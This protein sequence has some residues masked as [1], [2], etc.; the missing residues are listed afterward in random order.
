MKKSLC[1]LAGRYDEALQLARTN[2]LKRNDWTFIPANDYSKLRGLRNFILIL[3]GTFDRVCDRKRLKSEIM[4][5]DCE[6][7]I[8]D[9]FERL[10]QLSEYSSISDKSE[11]IVPPIQD[12]QI[13]KRL[14]DEVQKKFEKDF[15][16]DVKGKRR[17]KSEIMKG[18]EQ[19]KFAKDLYSDISKKTIFSQLLKNPSAEV[20]ESYYKGEPIKFATVSP[21]ESNTL[22]FFPNELFCCLCRKQI[23]N[24][25]LDKSDF[26]RIF[27]LSLKCH[28]REVVY[29]INGLEVTKSDFSLRELFLQ[30]L[31][32]RPPFEDDRRI[33]EEAMRK[34]EDDRRKRQIN[35]VKERKRNIDL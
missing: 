27:K 4:T 26:D 20:V 16:I 3:T 2:N 33:L 6:V 7:V 5:G 15:Y 29:A 30:M 24:W 9:V 11:E 12:Q 14:S 13:W 21:P 1:I 25:V 32:A 17:L 28:G 23:N 10:S 8:C 31:S 19:K 22:S 18:T 34:T 35:H